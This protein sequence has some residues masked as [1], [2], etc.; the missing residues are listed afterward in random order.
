[1]LGQRMKEA[2]KQAGLLQVDLAIALGDRYTH[3]DISRVESGQRGLR[4]DGLINAA[5]ELC[6]ST[7]YLTGLTD[8]PTPA[9]QLS[10]AS[11]RPNGH[12]E[13]AAAAGSSAKDASGAAIRFLEV[14]EVAAA[15]GSGAEVYDE[16][17]TGTVPFRSDWL[18]RNVINPAN[19]NVIS[20]R[21]ESMEPTLPDGSSIIVDRSRRELQ[22]GRMF[23]MR[24]EEGLVVKRLGKDDKSRWEVRSDN[25]EWPSTPLTYGAEIIGEVRWV[26]RTF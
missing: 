14:V 3:T 6:V 16:T 12:E 9:A 2:R 8:D 13:V 19:C 21:G 7:D 25:P 18:S 1:M 17:P 24:T 23:V 5:K 20:V 10:R 11:H 26:A 22:A 4:L 15:A